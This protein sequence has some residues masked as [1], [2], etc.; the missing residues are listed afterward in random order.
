MPFFYDYFFFF[1]F[2]QRVFRN[3]NNYIKCSVLSM[4][5]IKMALAEKLVY[6][7][8][9]MFFFSEYSLWQIVLIKKGIDVKG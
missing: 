8:V 6:F 5:L 3:E 2:F 7:Y 1:N 4:F 9:I